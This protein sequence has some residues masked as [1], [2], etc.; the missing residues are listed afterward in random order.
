MSESNETE[1]LSKIENARERIS[2]E[3]S[4]VIIGQETIIEQMIIGLMARGHALLTGVPGLG[5]TLLVKS[6]A[7][8]F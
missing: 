1:I 4:K 2:A 6:I 7:Q 3:L 8:T 5:K